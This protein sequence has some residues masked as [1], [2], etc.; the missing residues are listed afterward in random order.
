[1]D[2]TEKHPEEI[3]SDTND[4]FEESI[5]L[6]NK[7]ESIPTYAT[8]STHTSVDEST[9][10]KEL[11]AVEIDTNNR[12]IHQN[13][14]SQ[15]G[16]VHLRHDNRAPPT[17]IPHRNVPVYTNVVLPGGV[18]VNVIP[19]DPR[20]RM[21]Q[22]V[23]T[24]QAVHVVRNNQMNPAMQTMVRPAQLVQQPRG[25]NMVFIQQSGQ[26]NQQFMQQPIHLVQSPG[27]HNIRQVLPPQPYVVINGTQQQYY[28]QSRP[29][30]VHNLPPGTVPIENL[31]SVHHMQ[32]FPS[33]DVYTSPIA[34]RSIQGQNPTLQND[35][36]LNA[37][38]PT[39]KEKPKFVIKDKNGNVFNWGNKT[40]D[41]D[42]AV[43]DSLVK[44]SDSSVEPINTI[45]SSNTNSDITKV[46]DSQNNISQLC[47]DE[48]QK[49][50]IL[51]AENSNS[52]SNDNSNSIDRNSS[53]D[54]ND[55][56]NTDGINYDSLNNPISATN[57]LIDTCNEGKINDSNISEV[58]VDLMNI[59]NDNSVV[60]NDSVVEPLE[61]IVQEDSIES[62]IIITKRNGKIIWAR[63]DVL[64]LR[65]TSIPQRPQ[66]F[67]MYKNLVIVGQ[68]GV[69]NQ[70]N[71]GYWNL[72]NQAKSKAGNK[73]NKEKSYKG[74]DDEWIKI[75]PPEK[76]GGKNK[77]V[78]PPRKVKVPVDE[79]ED[80]KL[81]VMSILNKITPQTFDKLVVQLKQIPIKNATLLDKLVSLV[82]EKAIQ[83]PNFCNMYADMCVEL[84]N[85][86]KFWPFLQIVHNLDTNQY[87]WM[88]DLDFNNELAGPYPTE[89][90]CI[91]GCKEKQEMKHIN[92]SVQVEKLVITENNLIKIFVSNISGV[93]EYYAS[94]STFNSNNKTSYEIHGIEKGIFTDREKAENHATKKNSFQYMLVFRY[95]QTEFL[96]AVDNDGS[97]HQALQELIKKYEEAQKSGQCSTEVKALHE[98]EI[99]EKQM[100]LKK[101][102]QG[103]IRF[104]GELYKKNFIKATI[105]Y[106]CISTLLCEHE[107]FRTDDMLLPPFKVN[108]DEQDLELLCGLLKT[109]GQNLDN[110]TGK[111]SKQFCNHMDAYFSQLIRLTKDKRLNSRIRFNIEEVINMR[112]DGWKNRRQQEGPLKIDEIH[113]K[114]KEEE[115]KKQSNKFVGGKN[116]TSFNRGYSNSIQSGTHR[117]TSRE[118]NKA[119]S[120]SPKILVN[121]VRRTNEGKINQKSNGVKLSKEAKSPVSDKSTSKS[122]SAVTTEESVL[123]QP[124]ESDE[125]LFERERQASITDSK[126]S[127]LL[128]S[129]IDEFL[130]DDNMEESLKIKEVNESLKNL[131]Y[132]DRAIPQLIITIFTKHVNSTKVVVQDKLIQMIY[133]LAREDHLSGETV[134]YGIEVALNSWEPLITLWDYIT[135]CAK[136]PLYIEKL[137]ESLLDLGIIKINVLMILIDNV[138]ANSKD[139]E[140]IDMKYLEEVYSKLMKNLVSLC[141]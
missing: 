38:I 105:M 111:E 136:A 8:P 32:R 46:E 94:Y 63:S 18:P 35:D 77:H 72:H 117:T 33:Q 14:K 29:V 53:N 88:T 141:D 16:P 74:G 37:P 139:D 36:I 82:F 64:K 5:N 95:C 28:Q 128:N 137:L 6:N 84:Q 50:S 123:L 109:V 3:A 97:G 59:P 85:Q 93:V 127:N 79:V 40:D 133:I 104:I 62:K 89:V 114:M 76:K 130:A 49:I 125:D 55:S 54:R 1:M 113:Q 140:Y 71:M 96:N 26:Y 129:I 102:M 124:V 100:M 44:S 20:Q 13:I 58:N 107:D 99:E 7:M 132:C 81:Q 69:V 4:T 34:S 101:R 86:S 15:T 42:S 70:G 87:F 9:N 80:L 78:E 121:E 25:G 41:A 75:K 135:D 115:L 138:K 112:R 27:I 23:Y 12:E 110:L 91:N 39:P 83:E 73:D 98:Q 61:P 90:A 103:T 68:K 11:S 122:I 2:S 118:Q 19:N 22:V 108:N 119:D 48:S 52:D 24:N 43:P 126:L 10:E 30:S 47:T 120:P 31:T 92:L 60:N 134:K 21:Q 51:Q 17:Q 116:V 131:R 45:F 66:G 57:N 106:Q 56:N 67:D 65:P